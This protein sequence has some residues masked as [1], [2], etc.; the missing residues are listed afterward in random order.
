MGKRGPKK[1]HLLNITVPKTLFLEMK[2][3]KKLYGISVSKQLTLAR[4]QFKFKP[5][6]LKETGM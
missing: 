3:H 4:K 2:R 6:T 5:K 1:T